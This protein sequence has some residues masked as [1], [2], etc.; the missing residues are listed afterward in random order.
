MKFKIINILILLFIILLFL[1]YNLVLS[2]TL[3][4]T[5]IWL[6]KVF[7]FLFIMFIITDVLINLNFASIFKSPLPFIFIMSLL[8][9]APSSAFILSSLF[10]DKKIDNTNAN[11][12]LMFTYF[13]NPLF[14]FSNLNFLFSLSTVFRLMLIHYL[15]NIII[16]L[17]IR[18][19]LNK[20]QLQN[21]NKPF[22][23]LGTSIKKSMN[24]LIMILG[25]ITFFMVLTNILSK[26]L[27]LKPLATSL[28]KGFLEVT[29]GLNSINS[30]TISTK[31]KEIIAIFFISFGGLS[32]HFQIKTIL[33]EVNLNYK[34]FLQG[35]IYQTI[36]A[37][38]LTIFTQ[39]F[40]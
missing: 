23:N 13:A 36:I 25:T 39:A 6:H 18:K 26:T 15:S 24:T 34:Y 29:Q 28:L 10:K 38:F 4:A 9:G 8:S 3:A 27:S 21:Q 19:H 30:F 22:F 12:Y 16:Y 11:L 31:L 17:F 40:L 5:E 35:R 14:L 7:P 1:N 20:T 37:I 32:I 33:D 2:S